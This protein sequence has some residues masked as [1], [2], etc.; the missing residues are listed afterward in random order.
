MKPP[1]RELQQR[2]ITFLAKPFDL[3]NLLH[4]IT[5]LLS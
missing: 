2:A 3:M 5:T 1:L 4:T